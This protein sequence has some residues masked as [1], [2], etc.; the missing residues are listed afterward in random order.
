[1]ISLGV[2]LYHGEFAAV[3]AVMEHHGVPIDMEIFPQLADKDIWRA[4]R[5]D[6]VP[7]IDAQYGVYCPRTPPVIGPSTWSD[8]SPTSSAKALRAGRGSRAASST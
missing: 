4:V 1:M 6:M 3:S 2:A 5:D 7:A 8:W